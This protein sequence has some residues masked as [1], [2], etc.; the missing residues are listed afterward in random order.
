MVAFGLA[1]FSFMGVGSGAIE[2]DKLFH[3]PLA[4]AVAS[5]NRDNNR[6]YTPVNFSVLVQL[7]SCI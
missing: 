3:L 7:E 4:L 5:V 6:R 2:I 1:D